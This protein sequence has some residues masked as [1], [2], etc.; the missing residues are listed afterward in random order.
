MPLLCRQAR[1]SVCCHRGIY[2]HLWPVPMVPWLMGHW[3]YTGPAKLDRWLHGGE[4]SFRRPSNRR[5]HEYLWH[6]IIHQ[7][8]LIIT[9]SGHY[10][11]ILQLDILNRVHQ[12]SWGASL[13]YWELVLQLGLVSCFA[14]LD[15]WNSRSIVL[16]LLLLCYF[17]QWFKW[18]EG[19]TWIGSIAVMFYLVVFLQLA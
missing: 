10:W 15:L 4:P 14:C 6:L 2:R 16:G 3:P 11:Q 17:N 12:I 13:I 1:V 5:E 7:L 9:E 19:W 8:L 18:W